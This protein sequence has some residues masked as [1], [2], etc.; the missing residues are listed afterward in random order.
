MFIVQLL[1]Y[2]TTS[3]LTFFCSYHIPRRFRT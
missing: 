1:I 2:R 3:V